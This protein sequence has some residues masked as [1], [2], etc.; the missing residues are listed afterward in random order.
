M[1]RRQA[2]DVSGIRSPYPL[3]SGGTNACILVSISSKIPEP[4]ENYAGSARVSQRQQTDQLLR[5]V[6]EGDEEALRELYR[7]HGRFAYALAF[8]ILGR[9]DQAED[10][11]QEAFLRVWRHARRF[12]SSKASF[13]TWF[14]R[15]VRNLCIDMLRRK[16]PANRAGPLDDLER[17]IA[18]AAPLDAPILDRLV[19]REAFLRLPIDQSRV[20]EMSYFEGYTH[21]E[22]A[23]ALS[24]PEGTVKSRMRLGLQKLR[25]YLV[26]VAAS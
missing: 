23:E 4:R 7:S 8:R 26:G 2:W 13:S 17:Y 16:E 14:G 18:P 1:G 6:A 22:I 21:R 5:R 24:L 11:V 25:E 19:I 20:L 9:D 15:L 3:A 12:D 10:A